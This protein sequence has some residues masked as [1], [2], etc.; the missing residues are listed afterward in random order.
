MVTGRQRESAVIRQANRALA[1][2]RLML[3]EFRD[4][5]EFLHADQLDLAG[6]RRSQLKAGVADVKHRLSRELKKFCGRI[7]TI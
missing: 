3:G 4:W 5:D 2:G 1:M 6:L 7:S